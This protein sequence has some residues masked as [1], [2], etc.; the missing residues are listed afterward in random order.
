MEL[1]ESEELL[2]ESWYPRQLYLDMTKELE[3]YMDG[4]AVGRG[5]EKTLVFPDGLLNTPMDIAPL[6]KGAYGLNHQDLDPNDEGYVVHVV[7][8]GA[9]IQVLD[10][11]PYDA[12]INYGYFFG[13]MNR[14]SD[15]FSSTLRMIDPHNPESIVAQ[16]HIGPVI[17][18]IQYSAK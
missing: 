5:V 1:L 11:S 6:F 15:Q 16:G 13:M 7:E 2:T 14:L 3:G 8:D 12:F 9:H 17:F 4:V 10:V 18:D